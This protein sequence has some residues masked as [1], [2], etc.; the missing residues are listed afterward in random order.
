MGWS[1]GGEVAEAL[2]DALKSA[3]IPKAKRVTVLVEM[4]EVLT[5]M[6]WD[7]TVSAMDHDDALDEAIR[8]LGLAG[9]EEDES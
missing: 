9:D 7:D 2:A 8:E 6:D 4:V 3:G 1:G 5:G